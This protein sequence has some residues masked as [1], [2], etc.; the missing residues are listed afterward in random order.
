MKSIIFIII[1]IIFKLFTIDTS[2]IHPPTNHLQAPL[3]AGMAR[4]SGH[5]T[6][7]PV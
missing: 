4:M 7:T 2:P 3:N 6:R 1:P 5:V